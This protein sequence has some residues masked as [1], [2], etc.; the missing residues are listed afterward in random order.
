M[1]K[2]SRK[3]EKTLAF[4]PFAD[5]DGD[6]VRDVLSPGPQLS[7]ELIP[8]PS[9]SGLQNM[10]VEPL[11]FPLPEAIVEN[12]RSFEEPTVELLGTTP[13]LLGSLISNLDEIEPDEMLSSAVEE[14]F[15][16]SILETDNLADGKLAQEL[17]QMAMLSEPELEMPLNFREVADEQKGEQKGINIAADD[18]QASLEELIHQID[19]ETSQP[20]RAEDFFGL[21]QSST[22]DSA[23][24]QR[25]VVFSVSGTE[26]AVPILSVNEVVR[27]LKIT[28]V[29]N[30]PDWVLGVANLRGDII[31]VV[32]LRVFFGQTAP[33]NIPSNRM[34]VVHSA[35]ED[36]TTG[37]IVDRA[38]GIYDIP[39]DQ[40][41]SPSAQIEDKVTPFL[42]GVSEVNDRLLVV[43]ELNQLLMSS[44]M[45]Q[46]Q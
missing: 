37:L 15:E 31:S 33:E 24:L 44:E 13:D 25:Y 38:S 11:A 17:F 2:P 5:L 10:P 36:V 12:P 34:L 26:Y 29:P 7:P 4:D 45:Q 18:K 8:I 39:L 22:P 43:L 28:P 1:A 23:R 35:T 9:S 20:D 46:F 19:E 16:T 30:V 14:V 42:H 32:D 3:K 6:M 40:I 27:P 21:A 41:R